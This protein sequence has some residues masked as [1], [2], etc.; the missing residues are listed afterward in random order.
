MSQ[1]AFSAKRGALW[2]CYVESCNC[3]KW[4][5]KIY[6]AEGGTRTPVGLL[7]LDPETNDGVF[8]NFLYLPNYLDY[9]GFV[10]IRNIQKIP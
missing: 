7:P 9:N 4:L 5:D 6:G 10:C 1:V 8:A 3:K 2:S